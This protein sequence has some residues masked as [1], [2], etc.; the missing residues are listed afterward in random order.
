MEVKR[1]TSIKQQISILKRKGIKIE[2][3][4]VCEQFLTD[5]SY[6]RISGYLRALK[7]P[8]IPGG[9][10]SFEHLIKIYEFD[11]HLRALV[12]EIIEKIEISLRSR[13]G[14]Y[15]ASGYGAL[16][17]RDSSN[18]HHRFN[19]F[20][21]THSVDNAIADRRNSPVVKHHQEKYDG[22]FPIWVCIEFFSIG[23]LSF[24]YS[25][26]AN[27]DKKA[28]A[29]SVYG[30]NYQTMQ[31]WLH[32]LN[33]LRNCCAHYSRLYYWKFPGIPRIPKRINYEA[34]HRFFSQLYMLKWMYPAPERWNDEVMKPLRRLIKKYRPYIDLRDIDFPRC[35][36]AMLKV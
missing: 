20:R 26:M 19:H 36:N 9:E 4:S 34:T 5:V 15:H 18:F 7:K 24:F 35:W 21:F 32:C 17:Y 33:D 25:G 3:S 16:G 30:V 6:Y 28:L 1:P 2:D 13:I 22:N 10:L 27:K 8:H 23:L 14:D 12:F 11:S 31:N 29:K